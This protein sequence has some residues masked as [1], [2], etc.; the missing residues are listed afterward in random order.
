VLLGNTLRYLLQICNKKYTFFQ[1]RWL[2]HFTLLIQCW[3]THAWLCDTCVGLI[4]YF[5]EAVNCTLPWSCHAHKSARDWKRTPSEPCVKSRFTDTSQ[6]FLHARTAVR[7]EMHSYCFVIIIITIT[8]STQCLLS[9]C[10][11]A[12]SRALL[13]LALHSRR[14]SPIASKRCLHTI[15]INHH[16]HVFHLVKET[17]RG[18][19]DGCC[20]M[21]KNRSC[22]D[23]TAYLSVCFSN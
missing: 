16:A 23:E 21:V 19:S 1:T 7:D 10:L 3:T 15:Y 12:S 14:V 6:Q 13:D 22:T 5:A 18:R 8:R 9:H 11:V 2:L 17:G 4:S 20:G